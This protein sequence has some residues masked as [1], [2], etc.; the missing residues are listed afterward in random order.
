MIQ[1][2]TV[3]IEKASKENL[4]DKLVKVLNFYETLDIQRIENL[5]ENLKDNLY[6]YIEYPYIDSHYR[7]TYYFYYSTKFRNYE[8]NCVRVHIFFRRCY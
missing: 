5:L 1:Y 3:K 7:D 6:L 2:E 8:R 4:S